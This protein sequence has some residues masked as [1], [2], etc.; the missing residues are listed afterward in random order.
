MFSTLQ[1]QTRLK[2]LGFEP[3]PLDNI[4]GRKTMGAIKAFQKSIKLPETGL[5]DAKTLGA[6]FGTAVIDAVATS[7]PWMDLAK[8]KMGLIETRDKSALM[9]FLKLGRGTIGD[10]SK[11]PWCGDFVETCIAVTLPDEVLPTNPYAAINWLSFGKQ[12]TPSYGA[13]MVFHRGDPSSWLGHV[14]FYVGEETS[15]Y[16][17][18][19]GNQSNSVSITKVAKNKL[20]AGGSRWPLSVPYS[21]KVVKSDGSNVTAEGSVT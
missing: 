8:T 6:L 2:A 16:H 15:Y 4:I 18:L 3:G 7:Y 17:I 13:I 5:T 20:R 11:V 19:G 21:G 10:P 12:V 14:G 1:V 9:S